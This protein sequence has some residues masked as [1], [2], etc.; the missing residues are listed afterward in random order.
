MR[1][2]DIEY[3]NSLV[4]SQRYS[5]ANC[6]KVYSIFDWIHD[7]N[8]LCL[9]I[10]LTKKGVS[11]SGKENS[12]VLLQFIDISVLKINPVISWGKLY[13]CQIEIMDIRDR[14]LENIDILASEV[15]DDALHVECKEFTCQVLNP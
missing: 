13:F 2:N 11:I 1:T 14:G 6:F 9:E 7:R 15:E 10:E 4:L 12:R 8:I 3:C 5:Y